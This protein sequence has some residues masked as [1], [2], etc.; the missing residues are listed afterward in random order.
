MTSQPNRLNNHKQNINI[1]NV[2]SIKSK[3]VNDL[4]LQFYLAIKILHSKKE[5]VF[6]LE[7]Y[8]YTYSYLFK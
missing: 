3:Y 1:I 4:T 6:Q 2:I 8:V 7:Y 5:R